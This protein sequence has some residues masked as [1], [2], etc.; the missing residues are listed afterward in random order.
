M[1]KANNRIKLEVRKEQYGFVKDTGRKNAIF[2]GRM[3]S[4]RAIKIQKDV[5]VYFIDFTKYSN[6]RLSIYCLII[7]LGRETILLTYHLL[8]S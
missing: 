7:I 2:I 8:E 4:E 3:L 6:S 5:P 1:N